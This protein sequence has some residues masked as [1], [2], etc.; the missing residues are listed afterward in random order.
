MYPDL[1]EAMK[2]SNNPF[3]ALLFRSTSTAPVNPK[4]S[5]TLVSVLNH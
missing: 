2:K 3:V 1:E 5:N 4:A